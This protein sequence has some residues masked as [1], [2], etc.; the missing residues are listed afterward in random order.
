[1][2][3]FL[4][5]GPTGVVGN[6]LTHLLLERGHQVRAFAHR[7]DERSERLAEAGAQ[8]VVGDCLT[9]QPAQQGITP[10]RAT[11]PRPPARAGLIG[12]RPNRE[13]LQRAPR[14]PI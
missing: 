8:I 14:I 2:T 10:A 9:D 11:R 7:A 6:Y 3:R 13:P 12:Y 1:M 4:V 5:T